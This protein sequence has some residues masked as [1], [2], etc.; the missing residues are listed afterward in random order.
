LSSPVPP[1]HVRTFG[2]RVSDPSRPA[3]PICT[4][5]SRCVV[6]TNMECSGSTEL[7]NDRRKADPPRRCPFE[8]GI[9]LPH[10]TITSRLRVIIKNTRFAQGTKST[11]LHRPRARPRSRLENVTYPESFASFESSWSKLFIPRCA[12]GHRGLGDFFSGKMIWWQNDFQFAA[13]HSFVA[14][15]S[16]D[17]RTS[18]ACATRR[19]MHLRP[20]P[21]NATDVA[22][23]LPVPQPSRLPAPVS[24]PSWRPRR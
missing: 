10:S 4:T 5:P 20:F 14:I 21:S 22:E 24:Q 8:S 16:P 15:E 7:L 9:K 11:N 12:G 23:A 19:F 13:F 3:I 1:D 2:A 6:Q 17:K 18:T